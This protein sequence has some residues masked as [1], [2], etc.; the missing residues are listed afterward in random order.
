MASIVYLA[1]DLSLG[2]R[3]AV[4]VLRPAY[5]RDE[6]FRRRFLR[7]WRTTAGLDHPHVMPV[8]GLG[9]S[10]GIL[11]AIMPYVHGG[12]LRAL[13]D[14]NGPLALETAVSIVVRIGG[15]LDHLHAR[16]L[17]HRDVKPANILVDP[18]PDGHCYLCDFGIATGEVTASGTGA[19]PSGHFVGSLGYMAPEQI[20]AQT[21]DRRSDVYA[22]GCVLYACLTAVAPFQEHEPSFGSAGRARN[23]PPAVLRPG[24]HPAVDRLVAKAT[25]A[26][27]RARHS[28]CGELTEEL[29]R[30]LTP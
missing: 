3:V 14:S 23:P 4:K 2:R 12:D 19:G 15:A 30:I 7:E 20:A 1:E 18:R 21:V 8:Y 17:V 6:I 10:N 26:D 13:L 24:L 29:R 5:S 27:P 9:E 11:Y 25:A 28:S 22:L 16:G